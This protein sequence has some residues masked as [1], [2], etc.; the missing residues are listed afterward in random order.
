M[1]AVSFFMVQVSF[2]LVILPI[3]FAGSEICD[4]GVDYTKS[5]KNTD[6]QCG[7]AEACVESL[8]RARKL[9]MVIVVKIHC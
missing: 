6:T 4:Y 1:S 9:F 2:R 5:N 8:Y 7:F 3:P